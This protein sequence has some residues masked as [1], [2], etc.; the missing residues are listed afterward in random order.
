MGRLQAA[1]AC[2]GGFIGVASGGVDGTAKFLP[3]D[4]FELDR[5]KPCINE[6]STRRTSF[7]RCP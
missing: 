3:S 6:P 5:I 2:I 7:L 4:R 1:M